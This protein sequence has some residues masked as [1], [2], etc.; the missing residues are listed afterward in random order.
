MVRS[1]LLL[2]LLSL[3]SRGPAQIMLAP[4]FPEVLGADEQPLPLA[5]MG[6]LDAPQYNAADLDGDGLQD[7]LLFDRAGD[8]VIALRGDGNGN[9]QPAPAL[10]AG[11]PADLTDWLLL[12]DYDSDGVQDLFAYS[13]AFDGFRVYRGGRNADGLLTFPTVPTYAGL[14][15]PLSNGTT[16]PVFITSVDYPA[17]DDLDG[18]GDLDLLT[19]SV[20][21]GYVE[22]YR[23]QSV[24]RGFGTDTLLYTLES[25]CW[26]GFFESGLGPALNLAEAPGECFSRLRGEEVDS[27]HAGS[28][29]LTIDIDGNG[30]KDVMLGDIS[31]ES[32][33]L[34]L[35]TG[36]LQEAYISSQDASWPSDG[37]PVNVPFFPGIYHLDVDQDGVRDLVAS[38]SQTLNAENVDVGW[39][40]RN[41][42][43]EARPDFVFQDS[44]LLVRHSI[45]YGSR[46][47]PAAFD[48]DAD[49]R[50]DLVVGN[51]EEYSDG[52]NLNS[53]LRLL[54]NIT[55]P[56]GPVTFAVVQDD[57]LGLSQFQ[58]QSSGFA[59]TFGDLDGDGDLDALIGESGGRLI[60]VEN[61]A[62]PGRPATFADPVFGYMDI[63]AGQLSKPTLADLD[64]DGLTDLIVGEFRGGIQYYRNLGTV[65]NPRFDPDP[66]TAE[67]TAL[68]GGINT[69]SPGL[70]AGHAAPTVI[71]YADRFLLL[72]GNRRGTLEA[73]SFTDPATAS[74][75]TL[76]EAVQ[77]L[78]L[79]AF[80]TPTAADFDQ[81]GRLD[82]ILGNQRGGLTYYTTDLAAELGTPIF[83][84]P[85]P[86]F[87]FSIAPN[88]TRTTALLQ[89]LPGTQV[90]GL[91]VTNELGQLVLRQSIPHQRTYSLATAGWPRGHYTVSIVTAEGMASQKLVV[92]E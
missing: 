7:L 89:D 41:V 82:L 59:P 34:G 18:D 61:T 65:G 31:Y 19:F 68:L 43:T 55:P 27:R 51:G 87:R 17:I 47:T 53:Q 57:Y 67:N 15:Y 4:A 6:G 52:F 32:I 22:Y 2:F 56:D 45:D 77:D 70:S 73:Y 62:G 74:F 9:Y 81:D 54:R 21:G 29:T 60:Y 78:D 90:Q 50:P 23:N 11:F 44:Q 83:T 37:T 91:S 49:G 80:T 25:E 86:A 69:N 40:Y 84:P 75:T 88:P 66:Q 5:W 3:S 33:T 36:T 8:A 10:A 20:G 39:Y 42:G 16:T 28:T 30:L 58:N 35:N 76:S 71:T 64:R 14:R 1:V 63:D 85:A 92:L 13:A 79:G 48:F 26:G 24:E 72:T 38:P 46:S 12:R